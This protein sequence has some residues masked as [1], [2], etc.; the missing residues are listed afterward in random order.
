MDP[1]VTSPQH[2][3]ET[4]SA[5]VS[6][7]SEVQVTVFMVMIAT[8][9]G[10]RPTMTRSEIARRKRQMNRRIRELVAIRRAT[11]SL[12]EQ[13]RFEGTALNRL[14]T[15]DNVG[16]VA[17]TQLP[18][19]RSRNA[20]PFPQIAPPRRL[21]PAPPFAGTSAPSTQRNPVCP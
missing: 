13:V 8:T 16:S 18:A 14:S 11:L 6:R 2:N 12:S 1:T 7:V 5:G 20:A 15:Q 4:K 10:G 3:L 9:S 17:V 19:G 21:R